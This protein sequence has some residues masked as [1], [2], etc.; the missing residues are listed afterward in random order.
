MILDTHGVELKVEST[1]DQGSLLSFPMP[2]AID[3]E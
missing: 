1:V 3:S 2:V